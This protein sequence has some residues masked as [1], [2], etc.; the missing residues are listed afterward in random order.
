MDSAASQLD[1]PKNRGKC[2]EIYCLNILKCRS[3]FK[4]IYLDF[5]VKKGGA[6]GAFRST[7]APSAR[8]AELAKALLLRIEP[9]FAF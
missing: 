6:S 7:R 8:L 9:Q 1:W 5:S 4:H 3:I 2:A